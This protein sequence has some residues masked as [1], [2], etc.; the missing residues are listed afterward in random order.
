M[1]DKLAS[2]TWESAIQLLDA[3]FYFRTPSQHMGARR[4]Y[5]ATPNGQALDLWSE[6]NSILVEMPVKV[7]GLSI[8][9]EQSSYIGSHRFRYTID[10][11][12]NLLECIKALTGD[13]VVITD[14][15]DSS[16][17]E[18]T[19]S[20]MQTQIAMNTILYGPPG[21]GKT[22][23][24]VLKT[25]SIIDEMDYGNIVSSEIYTELKKRYDLL[26]ASG[27]VAFVTFHQ[28]YG[29][30]DFIEGIRP[31]TDGQQISYEVRDGILKSIALRARDN[32]QK[33]TENQLNAVNDDVL[34]EKVWQLLLENLEESPEGKIKIKLFRGFECDLKQGL[35]G[36]NIIVFPLGYTTPYSLPKHQLKTLWVRRD[37]IVKPSD[38]NLYNSS[39]FWAV[40]QH[41]KE[42][43]PSAEQQPE[44]PEDLKPFVLVID[45]INR[46]NI[47]KIFGE[48]ITLIEEDKRLGKPYEMKVT[49]PYSL[50]EEEPFGLPPNLYFI[51]TMNTSDRSIAILDTALRRRFEFEEL[52]PNPEVLKDITVEGGIDLAVM[53]SAINER[54]EYLYDRDHTIGHAYFI[55]I[56]TLADLDML[57]RR[58]VI[59]LLQEYFYEDWSK[60]ILVLKDQNGL[61]IEEKTEIPAGLSSIDDGFEFRPRYKVRRERFDRQAFVN[62]YSN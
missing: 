22:Y 26:N 16:A 20:L 54:I 35:F 46:G 31:R 30:E 43:T 38:I 45:E 2:L 8:L 56:R 25:M 12:V 39:Y 14:A 32:W 44:S 29:Y 10:T 15:S 34:F 19:E 41:L 59:P 1:V 48:L 7:P 28:S 33:A 50:E 58:K 23:S 4:S 6:K 24:V 11:E 27:Q 3:N 47:S 57:F 51:G 55:N 53:L 18:K 52:Q 61:F 49:L 9:S 37:K 17:I 60:V 21:T 13:A 36:R 5:R 40:L 62:I 42:L